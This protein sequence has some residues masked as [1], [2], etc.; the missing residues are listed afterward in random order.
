MLPVHTCASPTG[1]LLLI[2]KAEIDEKVKNEL[3]KEEAR[4]R[5]VKFLGPIC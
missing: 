4:N 1:R 3:K 2:G 5:W